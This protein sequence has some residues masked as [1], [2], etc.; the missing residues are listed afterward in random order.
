MKKSTIILVVIAVA[1]LL[2][3]GYIWSG[4]NRLVTI[5][6]SVNTQWAQVESQYQ[7]RF[8]LIPNLV[9]SVQGTMKQETAIFT[10]IAE[11]RKGYAGAT[12]PDEK[13]KAAGAVE[14][15]LGRLIAIMENYPT[16]KSADNVQTLMTEIAGTENRVSVERGRYNEAVK[17]YS[18][19]IKRFPTSVLAS[20]FGFENRAYFEADK[21]SEK[22]PAVKF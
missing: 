4:Y 11:A 18:I 12:T 2:V 9:A 7:R 22:A 10:A 6:E 3:I 19:A 5:N 14:T 16:L 1:V 13:A 8:D 20:V 17:E 15:S 21:G